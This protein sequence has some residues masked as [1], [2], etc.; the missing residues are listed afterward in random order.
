MSNDSQQ[1][2]EDAPIASLCKEYVQSVEGL[3][4]SLPFI[5]SVLLKT[6][7]SFDKQLSTFIDTHATDVKQTDEGRLYAISVQ[8]K[9]EHDKLH[10]RLRILREALGVT[11]RS[12]LVSL[13]S[14]YDAFLGR[15]IRQLFYIKPDLLNASTRVLTFSQLQRL[16]NVEAAREYLVEKEVESVLR[17]SHSRQFDWLEKTFSVPLRKGLACWPR[18]I[19]L[20]E[21]RNLFVHADGV[22]S[23]QYL[24]VCDEHSVELA[25]SVGLAS[26]LYVEPSY[27]ECSAQCLLEIGVKLAHV[28]WR[29]LEP[30]AREAA[31]NNLIDVIYDLLMKRQYC[32]AANLAEFGTNTIKTHASDEIRRILVMNLAI[33]YKFGGEPEKCS[34]VLDAEDW[35]STADRFRVGVAALRDDFKGATSFMK[36]IGKDGW[37]GPLGYREWPVFREFRQSDEFAQAYKEIFGTDFT[38]REREPQQ[39]MAGKENAEQQN[40]LDEK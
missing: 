22:V 15:L 2:G 34:K 3:A 35:S 38:L 17:E 30:N 36:A 14:A 25:D 39:S 20:T 28:L 9:P 5:M 12:F 11:P 23:S 18:F 40:S 37:P 26:Q 21:R 10:R 29:K 7:D 27:F 6:E 31:D 32:L 4:E 8:D 24:T 33:A 1:Q 19:E 16:K 13:V